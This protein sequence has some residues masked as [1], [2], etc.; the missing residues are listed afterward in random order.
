[1]KFIQLFAPI[2]KD[3][4]TPI[5]LT[6]FQD[7]LNKSSKKPPFDSEFAKQIFNETTTKGQDTKTVKD[8]SATLQA[9]E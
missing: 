1:M 4:T 5:N 3:P 6:Q 7:L 9:A 8:L 2:Y